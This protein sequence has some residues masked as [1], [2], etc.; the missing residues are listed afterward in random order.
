MSNRILVTSLAALAI[1]SFGVSAQAKTM[2]PAAFMKAVNGDSDKT[3]SKDEV[4]A[5]A[6]KRFADLEKDNDKTL[7][8]KELKGRLSASGMT[9]ADADKDKTVD[10]S[11][12]VAY[13][14]KLFDQANTKG[15]KTLSLAE[16]KTPAGRKLIELLH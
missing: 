15:D 3:L 5:Y 14:D 7:D 9:M 1:A 4:D 12:F 8:A 10:E 13:A 16:L 11:E 2:K 6:K